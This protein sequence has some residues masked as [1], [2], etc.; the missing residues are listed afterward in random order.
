M[1]NGEDGSEVD[2]EGNSVALNSVKGGMKTRG[3]SMEGQRD[4]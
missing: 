3:D 4:D 2:L 1:V